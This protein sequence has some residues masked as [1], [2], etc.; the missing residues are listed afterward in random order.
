MGPRRLWGPILAPPA[1]PGTSKTVLP[2][3]REHDF[4]KI[5]SLHTTGHKE[6]PKCTSAR[7][8]AAHL[9]PKSDPRRAK[10]VPG[11]PQEPPKSAP[12]AARSAPGRPQEGPGAT[13]RPQED[14]EPSP[15]PSR[16]LESGRWGRGS[17][18]RGGSGVRQGYCAA[19]KNK[20]SS[21]YV[22]FVL[23][24]VLGISR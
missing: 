11:A 15:G 3:R 6:H 21:L 17:A 5:K 23:R 8:R 9:N 1:L 24:V 12:R 22:G 10:P 2:L 14:P 18:R 20:H 13:R 7:P 19:F 16:A 4:Q